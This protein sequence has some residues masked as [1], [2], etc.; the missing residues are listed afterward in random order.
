MN[1]SKSMSQADLEALNSLVDGATEVT[2]NLSPKEEVMRKQ[3]LS[4]KTS[5][6]SALRYKVEA[7][8]VEDQRNKIYLPFKQQE[9]GSVGKEYPFSFRHKELTIWAGTSGCGKSTL[10]GQIA[11]SL[12]AQG[13]KV[14]I[15]SYEMAAEMTMERMI[16]Q[17]TGLAPRADT[18]H[19][20]DAFFKKYGEKIFLFDTD[21]WST[22]K[23]V[24]R[25][26]EENHED[27]H[28][29]HFIIDNMTSCTSLTDYE[30]QRAFVQSLMT[31]AKKLDIHIHLVVHMRKKQL[32]DVKNED[33]HD[34]LE[35]D[36]IRGS[37]T[38]TDT[39]CNVFTMVANAKKRRL[40][41]EGKTY[42]DSIPDVLVKMTKQRLGTW[43]GIIPLWFNTNSLVFCETPARI[44]PTRM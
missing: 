34:L 26:I 39:A 30:Q 40:M 10:T 20:R 24:Y 35:Q 29:D 31:L 25:M 9:V 28:C 41:L 2:N 43:T 23:E 18:G 32:V 38:I 14:C 42:D 22:D 3:R 27:Y 44:R 37:S 6:I 12:A 15:A 16:Q 4:K 36:N 17:A 1:V 5:P 33:I 19:L 21:D 7:H 11:L 13:Q 8:L